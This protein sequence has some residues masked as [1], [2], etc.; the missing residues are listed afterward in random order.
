[1]DEYTEALQKAVFEFLYSGGT[2]DTSYG[3]Y[4]A[5]GEANFLRLLDERESGN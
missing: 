5:L 1:M 2:P 3:L 4:R